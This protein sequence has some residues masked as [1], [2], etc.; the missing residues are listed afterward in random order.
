MVKLPKPKHK[1]GYPESQ[2]KEIIKK[3][4]ISEAKFN[5]AFGIN[6][7]S[8]SKTGEIIMYPCDV[9]RALYNLGHELGRYHPWD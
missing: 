1:Y 8:V 7:C 3:L 2:V 6:T 4:G 5:K 9:E